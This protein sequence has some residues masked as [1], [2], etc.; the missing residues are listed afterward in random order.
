M[1]IVQGFI[2][3]ASYLNHSSAWEY[4][5]MCCLF[6]LC[7]DMPDSCGHQAVT[8]ITPWSTVKDLSIYNK[9]HS[10]PFMHQN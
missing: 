6:T 2:W 5:K 8:C 1:K 4:A 9:Q 10:Q 7:E 3:T